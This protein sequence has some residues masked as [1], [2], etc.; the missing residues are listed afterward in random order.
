MILRP[1]TDADVAAIATIY[2]HY[3]QNGCATFEIEPPDVAEI[4]RRRAEIAQRG[5]P[6]LVAERNDVVLGYA[7][8]S[9]YR[10]RAAYRFTL[11]DSIYVH[12]NHRGEGVGSA[13]LPKLIALCEET[14]A[15]QMVAVIGDND[16]PAS[17]RLHT[18]FGFAHS[19]VLWSVGF[20]FGRWLDT[21]LMQR[22]LGAGSQT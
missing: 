19:G 10:P 16:N 17:V 13:L 8:A 4:A 6:Y 18:R 9:P 12:P 1:A 7:Y 21:I 15:R 20:K 22:S 2:S 14:G 11:E 3:V 5:L